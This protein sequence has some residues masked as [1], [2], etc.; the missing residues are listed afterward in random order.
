MRIDERWYQRPA[1]IREHTLAGG[2]VARYRDGRVDVALIQ[3]GDGAL[4]SL[5]KG[6]VEPGETLEHAAAREVREEAGIAGAAPVAILGV[7]ERLNFARTWWNK[8]HYF[9]FIVESAAEH[10]ESRRRMDWFPIDA[11]PAMFWP[12]Q[13]ELVESS[14]EEIVRRVEAQAAAGTKSSVQRQFS[15][16]AAAYARSASHRRDA[17]LELLI[18]HLQATPMDRVLDVATGTGFTAFALRSHVRFVVGVDLT[19]GMLEEARRLAPVEDGLSWVVGDAEAL[20]FADGT[21]SIA[22]CRRAPHHFPHLERGVDEMVRVLAPGGRLGVVDQVPPEESPGHDLMEALELLR[23]ASHGRALRASRWQ[24]LLG[25]RGVMLTFVQRVESRQ[26]I[27]AWLELAGA[28]D[29]RRRAI[30]A[31][32]RRAPRAALDQIGYEET[33]EPSFLKRWIVLVGRK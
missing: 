24:A 25:E 26:A 23:D 12:E 7:R 9:L 20:P 21:F 6:H 1:G 30:A 16:R 15:R 14:R 18:A 13:R 11:L 4:F 27:E 22:T 10:R 19:R 2:V 8:T 5:P 3:E 31:T 33:P 32:L 29:A 28:D 17:D